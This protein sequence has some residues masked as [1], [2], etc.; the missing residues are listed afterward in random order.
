MGADPGLG[1]DESVELLI[2][3]ADSLPRTNSVMTDRSPGTG[4]DQ[5]IASPPRRSRLLSPE[6]SVVVG[7]LSLFQQYLHDHVVA[8]RPKPGGGPGDRPRDSNVTVRT[9]LPEQQQPYVHVVSGRPP[10]ASPYPGPGGVRGAVLGRGAGLR[11]G[12]WFLPPVPCAAPFPGGGERRP[13]AASLLPSGPYPARQAAWL[14]RNSAIASAGVPRPADMAVRPI[15]AAT[16]R[17]LP[18]RPDRARGRPRAGR[19]QGDRQRIF[20]PFQQL[21]DTSIATGIRARLV[22]RPDRGNTRHP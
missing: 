3:L 11:P 19:P 7:L 16:D 5:A 18:R 14:S 20:A 15:A 13:E 22:P 10:P 21:G 2:H 1:R 8:V 17:V 9:L 6:Y 12:P 4:H